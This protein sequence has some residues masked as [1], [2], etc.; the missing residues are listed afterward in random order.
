MIDTPIKFLAWPLLV[1]I[2]AGFSA[3]KSSGDEH[4]HGKTLAR[5]F[6]SRLYED[7]I[8]DIVPTGVKG[9]DSVLLV[10]NYIN[11][12]I[13][14]ELLLHKAELNLDDEQKNVEQQ[15]EDYRNSLVIYL[16]EK[17]F[18]RQ[19][20]DTIVDDDEIEEYYEENKGNFELRDN[21]VKVLYV[22]LDNK[23][24][25]T[26]KLKKWLMSTD[27]DDRKKLEDY[28]IHNAEKYFFDDDNWILFDEMMKEVP[29][30]TYNK[31]LFLKN[32]RYIEVKDSL[33]TYMVNIKD[34]QV[35][36]TTSPL[37]F[38]RENI[39][40]IIINTRKLELVKEMEE[41][42][43]HEAINKNYFEIYNEN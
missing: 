5:V 3:C 19:R 35:K 2:I 21:I 28:C 24:K 43:Y 9:N 40:N 39:K 6:D 7:D 18:V 34:F 38:E 4:E 25:K 23:T 36:E 22:K 32:N 41:D 26:D 29:I 20:L 10:T 33:Y 13:R 31:E 12:W 16:Y 30:K 37:S 42:I 17:E 27:T 11:N 8:A 14:Q 1:L 15:L